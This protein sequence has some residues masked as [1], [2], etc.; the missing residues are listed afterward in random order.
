MNGKRFIENLESYGLGQLIERLEESQDEVIAAVM[1]TGLAG[2]VTLTLNFK[3]E[4]S[5]GVRVTPK[6]SAAVPQRAIKPVEMFVDTE[7]NH[8]TEENPAQM[9]FDN[10]HEL[11]KQKTNMI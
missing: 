2:K 6:I 3:R 10:V 1:E 11:K 4:D 5:V 9:S 8:L 7:T